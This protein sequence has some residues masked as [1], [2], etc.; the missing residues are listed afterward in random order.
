M[1]QYALLLLL[2]ALAL[3]LLARW[4][5][6][7]SGLPSGRVVYSDTSQWKSLEK[8][9]YDP[10]SRLSGR[11][12]YLMQQGGSIIP[13]EVKSGKAPRQPYD[14]HI[15]QLAAYCRLVEANHGKRPTYGII[16]YEDRSFKIDYTSKLEGSL[17][18]ILKE[19]RAAEKQTGIDRSHQQAAR[20]RGCGYAATCEQRL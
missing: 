13:V 15:Y 10:L 3:F 19:M 5:R 7:K 4:L 12:D 9:L 14:S 2:M 6:S 20:C 1:W 11:P 18:D 16:N 17:M 8:P